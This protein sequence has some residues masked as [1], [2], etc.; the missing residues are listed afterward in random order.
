MIILFNCK[1][2][3]GAGF[4]VETASVLSL[5]MS[6]HVS[7][8]PKISTYFAA[9]LETVGEHRLA[10]CLVV[11]WYSFLPQRSCQLCQP[12]KRAALAQQPCQNAAVYKRTCGGRGQRPASPRRF[13][14]MKAVGRRS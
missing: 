7:K 6:V 3:N 14:D 4:Q 12:R 11:V 13:F 2:Y 10:R 9:A 8:N 1:H 5:I